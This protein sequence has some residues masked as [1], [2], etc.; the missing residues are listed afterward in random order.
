MGSREGV[1]AILK[2]WILEAQVEDALQVCELE[3]FQASETITGSYE[4][5]CNLC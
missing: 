3:H 4:A 2:E 5:R 1:E